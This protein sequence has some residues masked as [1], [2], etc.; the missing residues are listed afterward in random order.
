MLRQGGTAES[1]NRKPNHNY[2]EIIKMKLDI[3]GA[4]RKFEISVLKLAISFGRKCAILFARVRTVSSPFLRIY[5][6]TI[7]LG[8]VALY[9]IGGVVFGVRLYH[10]KRFEKVD[11]VASYIYPFPVANTGRSILFDKELQ[12]KVQWAKT[13]AQKS[14]SELP[15]DLYARIL[16]D[17]VNDSASMQ[18]AGALNVRVTKKDIDTTFDLVIQGIGTREQAMQYV[19]DY[20]GMTLGQLE[21]QALPKIVQEKIR[22]ES[23]V[24]VIARH[25]LIKDDKKAEEILKKIKEGGNFNDLA[26]DNTE[27]QTTKDNG[28]LLADGE[29][30]YRDSGLIE[31]I[32]KAL[33]KLKTGQVSDLV[34]SDFGNH[35]LKVD[36]REGTINKTMDEWLQS[37]RKKY[38]TR[39]WVK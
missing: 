26:K 1:I 27:D 33:F 12:H 20:Y 39:V 15:P 31:P 11:L 30:I 4:F 9:I 22:E 29:F 32:E 10:Q 36:K 5:W 6:K 21:A 2:Q 8:L 16:Q 17:M 34:K 25:I 7:V 38:P 13:F 18:E 24:R 23:F 3:F 35:I 19:K 28:G 14:Q 37:L